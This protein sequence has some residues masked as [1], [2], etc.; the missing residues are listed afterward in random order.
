[1]TPK[2]RAAGLAGGEVVGLDVEQDFQRAVKGGLALVG[3]LHALKELLHGLE[4]ALDKVAG[5]LIE[6]NLRENGGVRTRTLSDLKISTRLLY[7]TL[8]KRGLDRQ[9]ETK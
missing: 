9:G 7:A 1:L 5:D 6:R 8:K 3:E 4:A 2:K